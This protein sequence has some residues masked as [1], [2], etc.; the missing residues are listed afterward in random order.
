MTFDE[1]VSLVKNREQIPEVI[2]DTDK[3]IYTCLVFAVDRYRR[4]EMNKQE[5]EREYQQLRGCFDRL[6]MISDIA[7]QWNRTAI[8]LAGYSK[9][10]VEEKNALAMELLEIFDGR[11]RIETD[12]QE[13]SR[14]LPVEG[15]AGQCRN[16]V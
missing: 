10:A 13:I 12:E 5:L 7:G 16:R 2:G 9:R 4:R 6:R 11:R 14:D 3:L 8:A 15:D 1:L